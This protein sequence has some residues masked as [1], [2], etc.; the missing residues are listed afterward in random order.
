MAE[1][2]Q[3]YGIW[4]A[5]GL[6]LLVLLLFRGRHG[7]GAGC[8]GTGDHNHDARTAIG[9]SGGHHGVPDSG[10]GRPEDPHKP[11]GCGH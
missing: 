10:E 9:G 2:L 5:V 3:S 11:S 8:C 1:F 7:H 6:F 4:I